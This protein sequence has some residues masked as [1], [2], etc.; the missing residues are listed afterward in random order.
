MTDDY[1]SHL[2]ILLPN[3]LLF[4]LEYRVN[5][6][7][8]FRLASER[9]NLDDKE[10]LQQITAL[11]LDE[12]SCSCSRSTCK[13]RKICKSKSKSRIEPEYQNLVVLYFK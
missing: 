5:W 3:P 9:G 12:F 7:L 8:K 4:Y 1:P 6:R 10:I 11:L 2:V 13:A